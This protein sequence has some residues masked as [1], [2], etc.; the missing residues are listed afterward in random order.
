MTDV[1]C[2]NCYHQFP[3]VITTQGKGYKNPPQVQIDPIA[4]RPEIVWPRH[5]YKKDG[6]KTIIHGPEQRK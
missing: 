4:G 5:E 6:V 1:I 2:P 3:V